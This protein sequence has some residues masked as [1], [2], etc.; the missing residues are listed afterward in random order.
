MT[1]HAET[2]QQEI[3]SPGRRLGGFIIDALILSAVALLLMPILGFDLDLNDPDSFDNASRFR[4]ANLVVAGV[5]SV[6]FVSIRGQTPGKILVRTKV[7]DATT[8]QIPS[9]TAAVIRYA[10][11]VAV[12]FVP[13]IGGL[14]GLLVYAW[15]LW[16]PQRQGIHD[17]AANTLVVTV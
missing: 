2:T 7:V 6:A 12:T 4:L 13:V 9:I 11:P 3:A 14:L 16:D 5:Y 8:R 10:V 15:L 1:E 17:K